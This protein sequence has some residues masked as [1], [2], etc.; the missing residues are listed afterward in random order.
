MRINNSIIK[1]NM[2]ISIVV[3]ATALIVG[4]T[5][6]TVNTNSLKIRGDNMFEEDLSLRQQPQNHNLT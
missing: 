3:A 4:L 2:R 5:S 1:I 6:A